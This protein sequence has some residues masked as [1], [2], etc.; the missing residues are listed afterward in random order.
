MSKVVV[1]GGGA[2]G[3]IAA[4]AAARN[5]NEVH[6]FEKNEKLGKKIFIT[7]KG[8]C[9]V[10]NASDMNSHLN[11]VVSNPKFLYSA[12]NAFSAED[13]MEL[14]ES[15]GVELKIE[16][17][18]R[19]F[20]VSDHSS[21]IIK[22]LTKLLRDSDVNV[23]LN[24]EVKDIS[25]SDNPEKGSFAISTARGEKVYCDNCIVATGGFSYQTTGSNGDGYRFAEKMGHNMVKV[26]PALVP[27]NVK[28]EVCKELQGLS[29]KNVNFSVEINNKEVYSDMGEMLFTHFGV[30]GP[31]V[32]TAS[33][34]ITD[35]I[36]GNNV[37]AFIDL[38]PAL[39]YEQLDKRLLKDFSENINKDFKNSIDGLLPKKM[40]PIIIN[41]SGIPADKKVNEIT[42]EDRERLINCLKKF[43][44]TITS[45]RGF[46]EAIITKGGIDIKDISPKTMESKLIPGLFFVGEVLDLDAFTGGYNL[47]IAWST[48]YAAGSS[49]W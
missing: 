5:Y 41:L 7:G 48:G 36:S 34:I 31:L 46:N 32:L 17:G 6:L 38:K 25:I 19:V 11:N 44:L 27:L 47:Q 40:I 2:A 26:N 9:N 20:P 45:T 30:S 29:L 3:M 43:E 18:Q 15:A 4:I 23:H 35:K 24:V 39:S 37:K 1:I 13:M 33:S 14:I 28:E 12:Y 10:T 8:R 16:R 42:K 21:D 49:I 22:A